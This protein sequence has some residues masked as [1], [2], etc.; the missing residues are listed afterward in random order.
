MN[1]MNIEDESRQE[2]LHSRWTTPCRRHLNSTPAEV[3]KD[4]CHLFLVTYCK[5][6]TPFKDS[7]CLFFYCGCSTNVFLVLIFSG[8]FIYDVLFV[9]V[10]VSTIWQMIRASVTSFITGAPVVKIIKLYHHF[11]PL[12]SWNR[13]FSSCLE[14]LRI[15]EN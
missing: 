2:D 1:I 9:N 5:K 13:Y 12:K 14:M 11:F 8:V 7:N 15:P 4:W 10:R 6:G 3:T